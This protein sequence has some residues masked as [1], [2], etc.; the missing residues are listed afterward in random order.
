MT[1]RELTK[2][3]TTQERAYAPGSHTEL[4]ADYCEDVEVEIRVMPYADSE[5]LDEEASSRLCE[6][7]LARYS[8]AVDTSAVEHYDQLDEQQRR[9]YRCCTCDLSLGTLA[10]LD[11]I[12]AGHKAHCL[13]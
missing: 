4:W 6:Y 7:W 12:D 11:R 10:E 1:Y 2:L 13:S 8:D 5:L 9:D 3:I